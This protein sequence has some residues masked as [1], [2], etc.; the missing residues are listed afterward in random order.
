MI[1]DSDYDVV[2]VGAG[3]GGSATAKRCAELGLKVALLEKRAEIGAPKR[4]AEGLSSSSVA[5]I[6]Q[7]IPDCCITQTI[8]GAFVYAPNGK[9]VVVNYGETK[10]FILERK[11]YDKWL[12]EEAARAGAKVQAKTEVTDVIKTNDF[13]TGVDAVFESEKF[14][15]NAQIVVAADG[16]ESRVARMA[17]MNTANKPINIDT[18][19]Q[20][21]M[22]GI[23][24]EDP[25]KLE[26]YMGN[27]IAPRGYCL[28]GDSEIITRGSVKPINMVEVGEEVHNLLGWTPVSATSVRDYEGAIMRI[29]PFMFNTEVGMTEDHLVY[30]W[31][32]KTGFSWKKAGNLVRGL[33]GGHGKGDYLVFPVPF[34]EP[35][36]TVDLTKHFSGVEENG[37]V[38]PMGRNQFGACFKYKHG[39]IKNMVLT[40]EL[41]EIFGYFVSEG[42][43]NS[44]GII[45]SNT[46]EEI[47]EF[48]KSRGEELFGFA[49]SLWK[50]KNEN[51]CMQVNFSSL[52][53]K[54]F[55]AKEFGVGCE[56]KRIPKWVFGVSEDL[57]MAFL[58]GLFRGDGSKEMSSEGYD[59]L[60]YI[61]ISKQLIYELW[62]LLT[63][64]GI[65][66]AIERNRKKNAYR[67]RIRGKQ[68]DKLSSIFGEFKYG[69]N[70]NRGF[71]IRDNMIFMGIRTIREEHFSGK[72]Y[73][74]ESG[75]SFCPGFIVHNCWVFP[76]GKDKANV[77]IGIGGTG[78]E[79]TAFRLLSDFVK[80][81]PGLRKGSITEVNAG[82]IPVGGF[83]EN[84]VLD[85]FMVV[86]DAA[87]QVNPIHGG[88][89]KE[90]AV[91]GRIA[92]E[93]AAEAIQ[94]ADVSQAAL[95]KYNELW[96][97]ERGVF[98]KNVEK[99]R[100]VVEKVS[101]ED[102][103]MLSE[104]LGGDD[105]VEFT[106]GKSLSKLGKILM[107][108]PKLIVLARHLL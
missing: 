31:N 63:T 61:S 42:N 52:V 25:H 99:L 10:G 72:V 93:V 5:V 69:E 70:E 83:L 53:L 60:S 103:N 96:W 15:L 57:K 108:D 44:N 29:T 107:K 90:A 32:K 55:F 30:V 19:F 38:Y 40:P 22:V 82:G 100:E 56:N 77:G 80:N 64:M 106:R 84:M 68:L 16:V 27:K 81:S 48:V 50:N 11:R 91:A 33:R 2:V 9:R 74:I 47:I 75:G 43:T 97:K 39:I 88:G 98:L 45:I 51:P 13:V 7:K 76:K 95:S 87:H 36:T 35:V 104:S 3:P 59:V 66:G 89:L 1:F 6:G 67:L 37:I 105:L 58:R 18:G 94:K 71:F 79:K 86:G 17:G 54:S 21:E 49:P 20:F 85:G 92:A 65:V 12:A 78:Y 41:M 4:C 62:M 23:E 28:T 46:D 102:L 34:S 8:D 14:S 73:D 26:I 101:D 24:M